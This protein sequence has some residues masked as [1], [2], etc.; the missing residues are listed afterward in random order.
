MK[1]MKQKFYDVSIYKVQR[2]VGAQTKYH[3]VQM[4]WKIVGSSLTGLNK[5]HGVSLQWV[6]VITK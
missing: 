4:R 6:K 5:I 1:D 3:K 2:A